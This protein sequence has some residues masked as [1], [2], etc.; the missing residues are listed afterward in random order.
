MRELEHQSMASYSL[1]VN[2][3]DAQE[4]LTITT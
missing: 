3:I 4:L 1:P 2:V